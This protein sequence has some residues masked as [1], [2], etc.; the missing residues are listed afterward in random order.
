MRPAFALPSVLP[1]LGAQR[2]SVRLRLTVLY[3]GLFLLCG[4]A[5]LAITYLLVRHATAG[6]RTVE[7]AAPPRWL[8]SGNRSGPPPVGRQIAI[9]AHFQNAVD[10]NQLIAQS[11]IALGIMTIASAL[12]GWVVAGRV[13]S[14]LRTMTARTRRITEHNLQERLALAG[15]DDE[16]KEL[17]DT[18][19][20]LL[21]RLQTAFEAQRSFAANASHEL[22]TPLA[23][24]RASL[25]VAMGKPE[26]LPAHISSLDQRLRHE[27]DHVE[28]LLESFLAL[29]RAEHDAA[30]R[31][32][33]S[34]G[35]ITTAVL[36]GHADAIAK[37]RLTVEQTDDPAAYVRGSPTLLARM[38]HNTIDNAVGHNQPEGWIR[39]ATTTE[40]SRARV[41]VENGGPLLPAAEV[42]RLAQ[43]FTRL[44]P[45][46]TGSESSTG[47]GLSIVAAIA[48]AHAG[49][50]DLQARADGGLRVTI[51]LPL[52]TPARVSAPA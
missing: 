32:L 49:G 18:I 8:Q 16:L 4:V 11:A 25:D 20:G 41:V 47:L 15:P 26:P 6:S 29:A 27:F 10:L 39:V 12:L 17:A 5:L 45:D 19:D 33:V 34:L 3:A 44:G 50:L 37:L 24:M 43:P 30:D 52:A 7:L 2:R 1:P 13:L 36:D 35:E 9:G 38:V 51:N 14:P 42:S 46:R 21:G 40:G 28:R 48:R 22:R 31:T 23:T